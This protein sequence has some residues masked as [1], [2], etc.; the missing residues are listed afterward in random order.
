[1]SN[2]QSL[3]YWIS[4]QMNS[5]CFQEAF[6][7]CEFLR[8]S[9]TTLILST[10]RDPK[11]ACHEPQT[12]SLQSPS[13]LMEQQAS[14]PALAVS[15]DSRRNSNLAPVYRELLGT[16]T[17]SARLNCKLGGQDLSLITR[18]LYLARPGAPVPGTSTPVTPPSHSSCLSIPPTL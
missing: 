1:M 12:Q 10:P 15:S 3:H 8:A 13:L 18:T 7:P 14:G 9:E 5:T 16:P 17:W 2:S 11:P 4:M 6:P